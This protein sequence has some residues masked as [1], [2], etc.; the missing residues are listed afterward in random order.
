[1]AS[2]FHRGSPV[3]N[4]PDVPAIGGSWILRKA[5]VDHEECG[6]IAARGAEVKRVLEESRFVGATE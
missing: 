6:G 1:M 2:F 4:E 5:L 3:V